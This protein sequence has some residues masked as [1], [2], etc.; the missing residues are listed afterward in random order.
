[1]ALE[2]EDKDLLRRALAH[3]LDYPQAFKEWFPDWLAQNVPKLPIS[4]VFGF[5]IDQARVADEITASESTTSTSYADLATVGPSLTNLHDG[6]YIVMFGAR[7]SAY[8]GS[9]AEHLMSLSLNDAA[10]SD[11]NAAGGFFN[12]IF[13]VALIELRN[14]K[15][16]NSI[17][18]KYKRVA[19]STSVTFQ[20]RVLAAIRVVDADAV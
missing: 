20:N 2:A 14:G 15:N 3:P 7:I 12:H 16:T 8:G 5:K 17:V 9:G 13:R 11:D 6:F 18:A 19:P 1:M 4:Q 10:A